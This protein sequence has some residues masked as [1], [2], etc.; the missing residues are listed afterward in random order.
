MLTTQCTLY[1][2]PSSARLFLQ[3]VDEHDLSLMESEAAAV[4]ELCGHGDWCIAAVPVGDWWSDL[5]PWPAP[6]VFGKTPFGDGAAQSLAA[7]LGDIL[8]ALDR[9]HPAAGRAYYLCGYSLAGLFALWAATQTD[10]FRGVAGVSPSVWYPGWLD[11]ARA[12]PTR[13]GAVYL[14]LGDREERAKNPVMAAVGDAVR[15][16][17]RLLES[18]GV[19]SQLDWNPGNHFRD[20]DLR[21]AK[22][23]AW[24]LG[25]GDGSPV[26]FLG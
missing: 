5:T 11:Y 10:R 25:Q 22:G 4:G 6:P 7:L 17:H 13:A 23:I 9:D 14:S 12:N 16:Q 18:A 21:V 19:P 3:P 8:P 1:G 20:S 15:A 26:P 2:S 24:L